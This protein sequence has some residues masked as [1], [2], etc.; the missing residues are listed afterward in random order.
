M[1]NAADILARAAAH[2]AHHRALA[3]PRPGRLAAPGP[4]E[5]AEALRRKMADDMLDI[6]AVKGC[7]ETDD[8]LGRG[9]TLE[10]VN[11]HGPAARDLANATRERRV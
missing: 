3:M 9:W 5:N 4:V 10:A 7:A 11:K 2:A 6:A 1:L 8:L